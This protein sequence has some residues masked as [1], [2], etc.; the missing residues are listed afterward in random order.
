[1]TFSLP[2]KTVC[3]YAECCGC[4]P[5]KANKKSTLG[6][7]YLDQSNIPNEWATLLKTVLK[8]LS[9][10]HLK[11]TQQLYHVINT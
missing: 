4:G 1:M 2:S 11:A 10:F 7:I 5:K 3:T 8:H 6:P 9:Y